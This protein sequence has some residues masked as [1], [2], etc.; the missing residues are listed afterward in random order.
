MS[1]SDWAWVIFAALAV[2]IWASVELGRQAERGRGEQERGDLAEQLT[3]ALIRNRELETRCE[4]QGAHIRAL[5]D[6]EVI[7][8]G[9]PAVPGLLRTV[10]VPR[11]PQA[12]DMGGI[13]RPAH[14]NPQPDAR[15]LPAVDLGKIAPVGQPVQDAHGADAT[16]WDGWAGIMSLCAE[17]RA[18]AASL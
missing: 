5:T 2:V 4:R 11:T 10:P 15:T 3:A 12:E 13:H 17:G 7:D 8:H 14:R 18:W 9:G 6:W 1:S 16:S